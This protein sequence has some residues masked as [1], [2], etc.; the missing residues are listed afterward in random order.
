MAHL[1]VTARRA[2]SAACRHTTPSSFRISGVRAASASAASAAP[3]T[4]RLV[5]PADLPLGG[6]GAGTV[7]V[8]CGSPDAFLR[9]HIP[10]AVRLAVEGPLVKD[11]ATGGTH[12]LGGDDF[13]ALAAAMG[14][15][16]DTPLIVYDGGVGWAAAYVAWAFHYYGLRD[17]AVL[18]GGWPAHIESG[19]R[20]G[21]RPRAPAEVAPASVFVPSP[22][23]G[24]LATAGDVL[25]VVRGE[26]EGQVLDTRTAGEFSGADPRGNARGGHVPGALHVP[27]AALLT[28]SGTLKG[29]EELRAVFEAARVDLS[30]PIITYCQMGMRGSLGLIA[31]RAAGA[32]DVVNYDGSM[33]EW[34]NDRSGQLPVETGPAA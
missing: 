26:A 13:G 28:P 17:V 27:H 29:R 14:V 5:R 33:K 3:A 23:P 22:R 31:L 34:L 18:D 11:P 12:L 4:I 24:A 20:V 15:G 10:G 21:T 19:G 30:K 25:D 8:D 6:A 2:G 1:L 16:S 32:V 7:L 9:A